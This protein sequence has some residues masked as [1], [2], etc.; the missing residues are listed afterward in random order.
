MA[1][2]LMGSY[3][4]NVSNVWSLNTTPKPKVSSGRL[5]SHTAMSWP[6]QACFIRMEK[7]RPAGPP[8]RIAI[9]IP[10]A[11]QLVQIL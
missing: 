3:R 10:P 5:R 11:P 8:P 6:G 2:W 1:R 9:R 4:S 7:Y